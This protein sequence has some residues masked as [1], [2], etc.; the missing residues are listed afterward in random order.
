[1]MTSFEGSPC[2][3]GGPGGPGYPDSPFSPGS[4]F[5]PEG[6]AHRY[7]KAQNQSFTAP[8]DL[9]INLIDLYINKTISYCNG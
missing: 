8:S 5:S 2:S 1:M 4:P 7:R 9:D 6:P 3:P